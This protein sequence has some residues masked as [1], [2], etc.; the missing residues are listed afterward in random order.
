MFK[1]TPAP[2]QFKTKMP[3]FLGEIDIIIPSTSQQAS[4]ST[5]RRA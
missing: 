5:G 1:M 4:S 3:Q 2:E